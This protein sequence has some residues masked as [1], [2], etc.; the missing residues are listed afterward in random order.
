MRTSLKEGERRIVTI[1]F[2]DIQGFTAMS[3][4]LDPEDVQ[5]IIDRC[6]KI[7]THEIEKHDGYI[8]KYEG[9]RMM[10]LF[11][12]TRSSELDCEKAIMAALGMKEKFTEVNHI[13]AQRGIEIGMRIGINSGLVVTGKIGKA[14]DQDFTVMGDAVNLASRLE[15]NAPLNGIM[16]SDDVRLALNDRFICEDLGS[17]SVKGKV[18]PV[19]VFSV[20]SVNLKRHQKW[21]RSPIV[22]NNKFVGREQELGQLLNVLEKC[23]KKKQS[24]LCFVSAHPGLGKSRLIHE[25]LK[26]VDGTYY[27]SAAFVSNRT[28]L[29]MICDLIKQIPK[30]KLFKYVENENL[31]TDHIRRFE[32]I[33]DH[34][35]L[36]DH[37][38]DLLN[39]DPD[40]FRT[41]VNLA[42]RYI[43]ETLADGHWHLYKIPLVLYFDDLQW[44]DEPSIETL[45]F[46]V[47]SAFQQKVPVLFLLGFRPE[48]E[49]EKA[50]LA[51][52]AGL[53]ITLDALGYSASQNILSHLLEGATLDAE[54]EK[55]IIQKSDGNPFFIEELIQALID[56]K[57]LERDGSGRWILHQT[58]KE[59]NV[60]SSVQSILMGRVDKL[61]KPLKDLLMVA[62]V[63]GESFPAKILENAESMIG[64]PHSYEQRLLQLV[65]HG[66]LCHGSTSG[67]IGETLL[68]RHVLIQNVVYD[69]ILNH[70]KKILHSI[71][72]EV[73]EKYYGENAGDH[74]PLLYW[75]FLNAG[76]VDKIRSYGLMSI[77]ACLQ[78]SSAADGLKITHEML[79]FKFDEATVLK[80]ID[81]E[82]RFCDVLGRR[83]DQQG[84]IDKL[85]QLEEESKLPIVS[86]Q[87]FLHRANFFNA[88]GKFSKALEFTTKALKII[89]KTP[90]DT[91]LKAELLKCGG[92]SYY[93]QGDYI[94]AKELYGLGLEIATTDDN[95]LLRAGFLNT[96]GLVHFN[97]GESDRALECYAEALEIMKNM[98]NRKGEGNALGNQGLVYWSL[99]E[100][101]LALGKLR[102][103]HDIF[104]AIGF[105]KGQAVTLGNIGVIH[106][107]LGFYDEAL[108]CY[109]KALVI[110]RDIR[111][112]AGEGFDLANMGAVYL[113]LENYDK[114]LFYFES[115][116]EVAKKAG[117]NYLLCENLN[118]L[119]VLYRE[120]AK[121]DSDKLAKAKNFAEQAMTSARA[122]KLLPAEIR[123]TSNLARISWLNGHH[124][125]AVRL[126]DQA[127]NM[128]SNCKGADGTEEEAYIN[129]YIIL[130]ECGY[131]EKAINCLRSLLSLI[132]ARA[133]RI[134]ESS[135]RKSFLQNVK[136]NRY[137]FEEKR[138]MNL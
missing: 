31:R 83:S 67:E 59:V 36:N 7:L 30:N 125:E 10:A 49:F 127:M 27:G 78:K 82:V 133:S 97:L 48:F 117:S 74:A 44:A 77:E 124:L 54:D 53:S 134:Q 101:S 21:E 8:D 24:G 73:F 40:S 84:S 94:K 3:E 68:F 34:L 29:G 86:I 19:S 2:L 61:E 69:M 110:R 6:F 136:Q 51:K 122:Q 52:E 89:E 9:D 15:S 99:G 108:S 88:V 91:K 50:G 81:A 42:F 60:P 118:S 14:R 28:V 18:E 17:I 56:Q 64:T 79:Q 4:K 39:L 102:A 93:S 87:L 100:Y 47:E 70:N 126:S 16:I 138:K 90:V 137:V 109:E 32:R 57:L 131:T 85:Q 112:F 75:H 45:A 114:A 98:G 65:G 72:G 38:D 121:L 25:F 104:M 46:V 92:I 132:E 33:Y 113:N 80:I 120:L 41:Q 1:L 43:V 26:N 106:H 63:I 12:V 71:V 123:A 105:K 13:L 111:D 11:G 129:H 95:I 55:L 107:K 5:L 66:F 119:S 37:S 128:I 20:E 115:G 76:H 135:Y 116:L 58:L 35:V 103:S 23:T 62:A 130:S 22:E 96:I